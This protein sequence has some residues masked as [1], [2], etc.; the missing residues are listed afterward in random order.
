MK[1]RVLINSKVA[2]LKLFLS[3]KNKNVTFP[4]QLLICKKIVNTEA[5][6]I[7]ESDHIADAYN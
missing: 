5:N 6:C 2:K 7:V 4:F 3:G 1:D